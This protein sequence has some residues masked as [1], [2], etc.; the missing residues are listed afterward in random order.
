MLLVTVASWVRSY[1]ASD[2]ISYGTVSLDTQVLKSWTY[3]VQQNRGRVWLLSL[4]SWGFVDDLDETELAP[5]PSWWRS[6]HPVWP[7]D[8]SSYM[9]DWSNWD[10]LG[11]GVHSLYRSQIH[12]AGVS[13]PHWLPALVLV[14]AIVRTLAG[15]RADRRRRRGLCPQ[16]A[17][18]VKGG[19]ACPECGWGKDGVVSSVG[20]E[21][22]SGA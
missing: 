19:A 7:S 1:A 18:D 15:S 8:S 9:S 21:G 14:G 10:L 11:L 13:L 17:Y 6:T 20:G 4:R 3:S 22:D 2:R 12:E 16:C 5:G